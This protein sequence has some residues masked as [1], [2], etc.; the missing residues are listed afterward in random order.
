MLNPGNV[1]PCSTDCLKPLAHAG[2]L[3]PCSKVE[4][5]TPKCSEKCETGYSVSYKKDKHYGTSHSSFITVKSI[6]TE[7]MTNGPVEASMRV[8]SDFLQYKS[9][10]NPFVSFAI[11]Y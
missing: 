4:E 8:Y 6:Q 9:G 5:K 11:K 2:K 7:I 10:T 1:I 3:Q